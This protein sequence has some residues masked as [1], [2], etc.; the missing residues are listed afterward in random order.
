MNR[1]QPVRGKNPANPRGK[2][3]VRGKQA[4]FATNHAPQFGQITMLGA[5]SAM[6]SLI[7][8]YSSLQGP[9]RTDSPKEIL[10]IIDKGMLSNDMSTIDSYCRFHKNL[11]PSLINTSNTYSIL[12]KACKLGK[13]QAVEYFLQ[14]GG[15]PNLKN[16]SNRTP[17]HKSY[18]SVQVVEVLV[19]YGADLNAQ[20]NKGFTPVHRAIIKKSWEVA[21]IMIKLGGSLRI[22]DNHNKMPINYCEDKQILRQL[23]KLFA[24]SKVKNAIFAYKFSYLGR[25]K[26]NLFREILGYL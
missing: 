3:P 20:D 2:V 1:N 22:F 8:D 21:N 25:V 7:E 9:M 10:S 5:L 12:H 16:K 13:F 11:I 4:A 24:W 17:L 6:N 18:G 19:K 15:N 26:E 23:E 14:Y